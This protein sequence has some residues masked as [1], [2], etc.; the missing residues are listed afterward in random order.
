MNERATGSRAYLFWAAAGGIF[1]VGIVLAILGTLFGLPEMRQRLDLTLAQ[2]GNIFLLLFFGFFLATVLTGPA[3]ES[4]GNKSVL[5]ISCALVTAGLIIFAFA[6]GYVPALAGAFVLGFGGGGL[7]TSTNA[8]VSDVYAEKRGEMLNLLGAFFGLGALF[9]PLVAAVMIDFVGPLQLLWIATAL[10][11]LCF[12]AYAVLRFP[13]SHQQAAFSPLGALKAAR[14]PG[15]LL[16][17]TML[18]FQ[19]GNESSIGGWTST[20]LGATGASPRTATWVLAGYWAALMTGRALSAT[21]LGSMRKTSL[22]LASAIG[23]VAGALVLLLSS[24]VAMMAAGAVLIGLSYAAVYPTTLAI[25]GDRNLQDPGSVFG[26]L[27]AVGLIG[28]TAFPWALGQ[29]SEAWGVR[30]GM[31]LPVVGAVAVVALIV[32]IAG[33]EAAPRIQP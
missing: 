29:I 11:G 16:M 21:L 12:C 2:Q 32:V 24:S 8:L 15:V 22:V 25:A 4:F 14:H 6:T 27:F 23:S 20:Y 10:S 30:F 17:A 33:R 3:I 1:L 19:S 18:F 9:I 7:N 28:G 13:A 26:F 31:V 5:T